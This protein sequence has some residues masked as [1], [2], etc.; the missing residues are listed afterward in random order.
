MLTE[1]F[2]TSS[3]IMQQ[4]I[5]MKPTRTDREKKPFAVG[6]TESGEETLV[7]TYDYVTAWQQT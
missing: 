7:Y 1:L 2:I 4:N 5:P 3:L 6:H